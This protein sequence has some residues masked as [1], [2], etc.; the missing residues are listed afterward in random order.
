MP[1]LGR[2]GGG[3]LALA[4]CLVVVL[5]VASNAFGAE[6]DA[7]A[8][9]QNG[10]TPVL[11][12]VSLSG[13]P[14]P[15]PA[16]LAKVLLP[17]LSA[18]A[19]GPNATI[20]VVDPE[21]GTTLFDR[22]GSTSL[23]PA[24]TAK[25]LTAAATSTALGADSQIATRVVQGSAPDQVVLVGGGDP[26]LEV[27]PSS[28]AASATDFAKPRAS[29]KELAVSTAKSL[30]SAAGE[31]PAT[32]HVSYDTSLFTGPQTAPSWPS[33]YVTANIVAP[34]TP[35]MVNGGRIGLSVVSNPAAYAAKQFAAQLA[36]QGITVAPTQS[37]QA[38][39]PNAAQL[40]QVV[41]P[42]ISEVVMQTLTYSDNTAAE[43]LA[44][45][46]GRA[47]VGNASFSG[48]ADATIKVLN[49]LGISTSGVTLVDGSG[50]S[51]DDA[52]PA[53]VLAQLMSTVARQGNAQIWAAQSGTPIAGLTGT[54][55]VQFAEPSNRAGRGVVRAKTGTLS[56]LTT[57]AG[58]VAD[59]DGALL[60]FAIMAPH[61]GPNTAAEAARN[62]VASLLATCGCR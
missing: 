12:P 47:V 8:L 42:P 48:G 2:R 37:A 59:T 62:R 3:I 61:A 9:P 4:G 25:L 31:M 29:L 34:I 38:A 22:G 35:L 50:L 32:I 52:V 28:N 46:A 20:S 36:A 16:G 39:P 17:A 54:L 44:H 40:A 33:S 45:L 41:S 13:P 10:P 53:S 23:P 51:R 14:K 43:V 11:A 21:N 1:D 56:G 27:A 19:L 49:Q 58:T 26:L 24:S 18:R 57:L 30:K 60:A 7:P 6:S 5:G 55:A 15:T